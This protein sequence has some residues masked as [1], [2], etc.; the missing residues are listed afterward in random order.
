[1]KRLLGLVCLAGVVVTGSVL[2]QSTAIG[3]RLVVGNKEAVA[4]DGGARIAAEKA[5]VLYFED[6]EPVVSFEDA[7]LEA[8][9][10]GVIG[11]A[12]GIYFPGSRVIHSSGPL[13]LPATHL[14]FD[15]PIDDHDGAIELTCNNGKMY[16]DG[17]PTGISSIC[18]TRGV[19]F[20]CHETGT[21]GSL[22]LDDPTCN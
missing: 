6:M 11:I 14:I 10:E 1:M 16:R 22:D 20:T 12:E 5:S 2:A 17:K 15:T 3:E 13:F 4:A 9:A 19:R 18:L 8:G 7:I 21:G